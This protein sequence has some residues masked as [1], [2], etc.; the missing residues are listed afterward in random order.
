MENTIVLEERLARCERENDEL[1]LKVEEL[2]DFFEN[3]SMPLHWVDAKGIIIWANQAELDALGYEKEEY[4]GFP[5]KNFHADPE[6]IQDIL[7]RLSNDETLY[8][9]TARLKCKDGSV[10]HVLINSN[11][12]RKDG[13]FVH[14]RC[15]TRDI[16]DRQQEDQ[17]KN[18]FLAM[19][20]HELKTPLT[21]VASYIQILLKK[22]QKNT[23]DFGLNVLKRMEVQVK[24]MILM[25]H[26]FLNLARIQDGKLELNRI[27]FDIDQLIGEVVE[28]SRLLTTIHTIE[29][30]GCTGVV[31]YADQ[32][33]IG[34][35]L[36]N[37]VG[38]AIKYSP[39][40]GPI[41]IGCEK[42]G[43]KVRISVSD[44]GI[45]IRQSDQTRLFERFYRINSKSNQGASGFGIGLYLVSE[46]LQQHNSKIEVK[47]VEN[48]GSRFY[49]DLDGVSI[50][51]G[52][53]PVIKKS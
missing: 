25:A 52:V 5:I 30:S 1:K 11:V 22:K 16:T 41:I 40:G 29:V 10:K 36:T 20:S 37:L 17:R 28:S 24:K 53:H 47:S 8:D 6:V 26:D 48:Q 4:I 44:Q 50:A 46:I 7:Y 15:F 43:D 2:S 31:V 35:V 18:D 27:E 38:N 19:V 9:Y 45:G 32:D 23:D 21:V 49:F 13:K 51:D 34:Q 3:A 12:L 42:L 39:Q 33:K 14:T